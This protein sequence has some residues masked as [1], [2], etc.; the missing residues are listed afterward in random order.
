ML[1]YAKPSRTTVTPVQT[2]FAPPHHNPCIR[3]ALGKT[4]LQPKLRVGA[5]DD[6]AEAEADRVA[7]QVMRMPWSP[8]ET[9]RTSALDGTVQRMCPACE[10]E[11]QRNP[12]ELVRRQV[13]EEEEEALQMKPVENAVQRKCQACGPEQRSQAAPGSIRT[14]KGTGGE[15]ATRAPMERSIRDLGSGAPLPASERE[16]FEPRFGHDFSA[17]RIHAGDSADE[18]SRSIGARA[19]TLRNSIAF[20]R[21]EYRP[22]SLDGR[23]LIAHELT[24]TIQQ[25]RNTRQ[26]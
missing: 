20:A 8:A 4:R 9:S 17:V 18:A 13:E 2:T 7:E 3:Q 24:H 10:D 11:S 25:D 23:R 21:G 16:F 5:L 1:T 19:F 6:P 22:G 26:V 14:A 15:L 12:S